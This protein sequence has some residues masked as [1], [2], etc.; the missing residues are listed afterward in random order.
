MN[1]LLKCKKNT[2]NLI[3]GETYL[4]SGD[5]LLETTNAIWK[6]LIEQIL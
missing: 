3:K 2:N 4:I 5:F 6:H 1:F